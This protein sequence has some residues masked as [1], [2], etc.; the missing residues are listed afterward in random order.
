ME[1]HQ[2]TL[3]IAAPTA[4]CGHCG[5]M[6]SLDGEYS[7][8][9]GRLVFRAAPD[10]L[11]RRGPDYESCCEGDPVV[12]FRRIVADGKVLTDEQVTTLRAIARELG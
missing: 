7:V 9:D 2:E 1:L 3:G 11:S 6:S 5:F 12:K 8:E 10:P 4:Q